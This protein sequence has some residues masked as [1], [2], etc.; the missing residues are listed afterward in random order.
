MVEEKVPIPGSCLL[1]SRIGD[2]CIVGN[3][4]NIVTLSEDLIDR[5]FS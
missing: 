4:I 1:W 2:F 3:I 5:E